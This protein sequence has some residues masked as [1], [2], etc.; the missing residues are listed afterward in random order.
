[1]SKV[2]NLVNDTYQTNSQI[3]K[4][5]LLPSNEIVET[6]KFRKL[7]NEKK[8]S[9]STN[10]LKDAKSI[11]KEYKKQYYLKNKEKISKQKKI[12]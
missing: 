9:V 4:P 10:T 2:N 11:K 3:N 8:V 7:N 5:E 1:M 6:K 12:A